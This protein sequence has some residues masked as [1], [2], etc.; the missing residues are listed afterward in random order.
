MF[1]FIDEEWT[2]NPMKKLV[3]LATVAVAV[4]IFIQAPNVEAAN[5]ATK[6]S[7]Q[8]RLDPSKSACRSAGACNREGTNERDKKCNAACTIN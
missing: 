1:Q 8:C 4:M 2:G 5:C 6:V 7:N 3:V